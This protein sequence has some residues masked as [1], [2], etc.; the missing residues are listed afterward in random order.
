[1]ATFLCML[2]QVH[3]YA[4]LIAVI[5]PAAIKLFESVY[6]TAKVSLNFIIELPELIQQCS[7]KRKLGALYGREA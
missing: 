3:L 4:S 6:A 1:M 7:T 2:L 5:N